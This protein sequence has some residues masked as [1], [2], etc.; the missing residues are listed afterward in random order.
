[1]RS[2]RELF[3]PVNI[4]GLRLAFVNPAL[5]KQTVARAKTVLMDEKLDPLP[6]AERQA[7]VMR[8]IYGAARRI[9][10]IGAEACEERANA[11]VRFTGPASWWPGRD[12]SHGACLLAAETMINADSYFLG[13]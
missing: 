2:K 1:M 5:G 11:E 8:R 9:I 6:E 10:C 4:S 13:F 3:L 12:F 7:N